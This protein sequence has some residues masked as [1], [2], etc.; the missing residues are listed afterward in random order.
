M[1]GKGDWQLRK[2][3]RLAWCR[4]ERRRAAQGLPTARTTANGAC[5]QRVARHNAAAVRI[6]RQIRGRQGRAAFDRAAETEERLIEEQVKDE[7]GVQFSKWQASHTVPARFLARRLPPWL[8]TMS[9]ALVIQRCYRGFRG[10]QIYWRL[11]LEEQELIVR[12][13]QKQLESTNA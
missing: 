8:V 11:F 12:E 10:R 4:Q 7:I 13:V 2:Q 3:Q 9:A 5:Q 6:Q 1:K